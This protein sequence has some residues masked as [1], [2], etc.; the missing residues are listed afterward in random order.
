MSQRSSRFEH[1][2]VAKFSRVLANGHT[3]RS[4]GHR[5]W[6]MNLRESFWPTAIFKLQVLQ[7]NLAVAQ[8]RL[9]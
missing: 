7:L 6:W 4:Q 5:P 8:I 9:V 3:Y 2:E 1:F